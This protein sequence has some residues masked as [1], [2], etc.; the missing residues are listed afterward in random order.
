MQNCGSSLCS[1]TLRGRGV[2]F[3]SVFSRK[4]P[5]GASRLLPIFLGRGGGG[6]HSPRAA[7]LLSP[8]FQLSNLLLSRQN[9]HRSLLNQAQLS[10]WGSFSPQPSRARPHPSPI[11]ATALPRDRQEQRAPSP[12]ALPPLLPAA[13]PPEPSAAAAAG[14][15]AALPLSGTWRRSGGRREKHKRERARQGEKSTDQGP[16]ERLGPRWERR[17]GTMDDPRGLPRRRWR[18]SSGSGCSL[19]SYSALSLSPPATS[20]VPGI[21][22]THKRQRA[23][24]WAIGAAGGGW[25]RQ[26]ILRAFPW[27]MSFLLAPRAAAAAAAAAGVPSPA[28]RDSLLLSAS[29]TAP[30]HCRSNAGSAAACSR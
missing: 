5:L 21:G 19:A 30:W 17:E 4:T 3:S 14:S 6:A 1:V 26:R 9:L 28:T 22:C 23:K 18:L 13:G 27:C 10:L 12:A 24:E 29:P 2:A 15:A 8:H 11:P 7:G 20:W 16:R 25:R